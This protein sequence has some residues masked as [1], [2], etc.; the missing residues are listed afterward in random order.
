MNANRNTTGFVSP[1]SLSSSGLSSVT[2]AAVPLSCRVA[3]PGVRAGTVRR[4]S[5]RMETATKEKEGGKKKKAPVV[6]STDMKGK[7]VWTLRSATPTDSDAIFPLVE[8]VLP[9]DLVDDFLQTSDC[10]TVCEATI[11]GTKEGEGFLPKIMGVVLA[12]INSY[13]TNE[14]GTEFSKHALLVT[15]QVDKEFPEED[16]AQKMLLGSLKK[17]KEAKVANVSHS[18]DHQDRIDILTECLFKQD[19]KDDLGLPL[20]VCNL[21]FENPDPKK[22]M[23]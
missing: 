8:H 13:P 23:L 1:L 3:T 5:V 6:F 21:G 17:M 20:F 16:V 2:T 11:K 19:G 4:A 7:I 12:D 9:R 18:N 15:I 10:C 14:E 22:K